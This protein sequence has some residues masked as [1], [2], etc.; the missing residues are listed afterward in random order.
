MQDL[1]DLVK[2]EAN[3][4][5]GDLWDLV[6]PP[7]AQEV[8][9]APEPTRE[10]ADAGIARLKARAATPG[11]VAS[12]VGGVIAKE[13]G[14]F[15]G[16]ALNAIPDLM[17]L[18]TK[19]T[20]AS[21]QTLG[22]AIGSPTLEQGGADLLRTT[23]GT[24]RIP[25]DPESPFT[26]LGAGIGRMGVMVAAPGAVGL[27]GLAALGPAVL[28][29]GAEQGVANFH[30]VMAE[31]GDPSKA[32]TALLEGSA[33]G[34]ASMA[35]PAAKILQR[36]NSASGGALGKALSDAV[37]FG[38]G[39]GA[40]SSAVNDIILEHATGKEREILD[41]A[42]HAGGMGALT[43]AFGSAIGSAVGMHGKAAE[44]TDRAPELEPVTD[45][46]KP[47][48]P[49]EPPTRGDDTPPDAGLGRFKAEEVPPKS[50]AQEEV[51]SPPLEEPVTPGSEGAEVQSAQT[52][53]PPV[54]K[55]TAREVETAPPGGGVGVGEAVS[56]ETG[57]ESKGGAKTND[58]AGIAGIKNEVVDRERAAMGLEP[59]THAE[60][61][62]FQEASDKAA[63]RL[64]KNPDAGRDLVD[65]VTS[66]PRPLTD[67]EGAILLRETVRVRA[68]RAQA[69][70][71]VIDA[72]ES[73]VG[74]D[75]AR[76]A[77]K[78]AADEYLKIGEAATLAGT[79]NA[80]A[81]AFRRA[82]MKADYSLAEMERAARVS[83]AGE[84]L[85][86]EQSKRVAD[87]HAR[88]TKAEAALA[89]LETKLN[90]RESTDK[91]KR[92][93]RQRT[94]LQKAEAYL[95]PK[96]DAAL[97]RLTS[98]A[99][100]GL[101]GEDLA[102]A[103]VVGAHLI[104]KGAANLE[105]FTTKLVETV[106][107]WIRPHA[108]EVYAAAQKEHEAALKESA[109]SK[110][111]KILERQVARLEA[112]I[113]ANDIAPRRPAQGPQVETTAKLIAR[114]DALTERI[115]E[116]RGP[117]E[118]KPIAGEP[119]ARERQ[120][121]RLADR[122]AEIEKKIAEGDAGP[123]TKS[124]QGPEP[125][126]IARLK[127]KRDE[128]TKR[129]EALRAKPKQGPEAPAFVREAAALEKQ[130]AR[131]DERVKRR[132]TAS[133]G[134]KQGPDTEVV[135]RLKAQRDTL[136]AELEKIR[137]EENPPKSDEEKRLDA[138]KSGL[139]RGI[140][141]LIERRQY[142]DFGPRER[143]PLA[144]D[145]EW[146]ALKAESEAAKRDFQRAKIQFER[147]HR[148]RARKAVDA[149]REAKGLVGNVLSSYDLSAV[150]RQGNFFTLTH[151]I[152]AVKNVRTMLGALRSQEAYDRVQTA[153]KNREHYELGRRSGLELTDVAD[154]LTPQEELLRSNLANKI[155]GVAHSN[156][157]FTT[158][159]NLQRVQ[160]FDALIDGAPSMTPERAKLIARRVNDLTGR[161][162]IKGLETPTKWLGEILWAPKLYIARF[163][164]L[165]G[166][167][168]ATRDPYVRKQFIKEYAKFAIGLGAIYT[169]AKMNGAEV[170]TDSRSS[171]F[172]KI[173]IGN[174]RIDPTAGLAQSTVVVSQ[175]ATGERKT[176]STGET[177][178]ANRGETL[179]RFLRMKLSPVY[180]AGLD[181]L[182]GENV[183]GEKV[184]PLGAAGG[185][186]VP[187]SGR[188]IVDA[189]QEQGVARGTAL[190]IWALFGAGM[191]TFDA[192]A[193]AKSPSHRQGR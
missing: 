14:N 71:A 173:K 157:A 142:E 42:L 192:H 84:A 122:V 175:M 121:Q 141:K 17:A 4:P 112:R 114:R 174:T 176:L 167:P 148:S 52:P 87:L 117:T 24:P 72:Q 7:T 178:P 29:G 47:S 80:Q 125:E 171:D 152:Q 89:D 156:R 36:I 102:D 32:F 25:T 127:A 34:G 98:K 139:R 129:L 133:K 191:Q 50:Q 158:Y 41:N 79:K 67:E 81:L 183:I 189:I 190:S 153:I 146:I 21:A 131:L 164:Q 182:L 168:M 193:K 43:V 53:K 179:L 12:H 151:P 64:E 99:R 132:E 163:K 55:G 9:Y 56:R 111:E 26:Q 38:G 75:D 91:L 83:N 68:K 159:L 54:E 60:R 5:S 101:G 138:S 88:I 74:L 160:A 161:G 93:V 149:A 136:S 106:G 45:L 96:A 39:V 85:S 169:L 124:K 184:T 63:K 35:L 31:T 120:A 13:A 86:P 48:E 170:E 82:L 16:E 8:A 70:Q 115:K 137:R 185:L 140:G 76:A 134:E 73:G 15:A 65:E 58:L 23:E 10:E 92:E 155:P 154:V 172:G 51:S 46:S 3:A 1:W 78:K 57:G 11:Q 150:F 143:K 90:E 104:T 28:M 188:D 145:P 6:R 177:A 49:V 110:R 27:E 100:S 118:P 40:G 130:I 107:E 187:L 77:A 22:H 61:T 162:E 62:T 109:K 180:G 186:L 33:V 147:A 59:A 95:K 18:P 113:K 19:V 119:T 108:S 128:A 135:A 181:A 144:T 2:P 105:V 30:T 165:A 166:T 116:L 97:K 94:K 69:E 20:A 126:D 66:K 37:I 123:L 103:A 44:V